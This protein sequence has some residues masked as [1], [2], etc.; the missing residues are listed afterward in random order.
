MTDTDNLSRRRFLQGTGAAATAAA[1]AGCTGGDGDGDDEETET[2]E[3]D[4]GTT[5]TGGDETSEETTEQDYDPSKEVRL[6]GSTMDTLDPVKATDTSSGA[7]IQNIFDGLTNYPEGQTNVENLLAE[8]LDVS[9]D[10]TTLTFSLKQGVTYNN[11]DELTAGDIV[12]S[13]ERLAASENSRRSS[14]LLADLGVA[15]ETETETNEE[16]EE[17]ERYVP[18]SIEVTAVDDYTVEIQLQQAF[19]AATAMIAYS[20]F[21]PIPEGIVGDIEGYDGQMDY[22]EFATTNPVGTGPYE[23]DSWEQATS[24]KLTSRDDYHGEEPTNA[25]LNYTIFQE[26][27]PAYTYATVNVN[28][29]FPVVPNAKFQPDLRSFDGTDDRGRRY[30]TYGPFEENGLT[31]DYYEVSTLDCRYVAFN[32]KQVPKP[33]REAVGYAMN[34]QIITEELITGPAKQAYFFTP[35]GIFPGGPD[36]YTERQQDYKYGYQSS[37]LQAAKQVMEDAGYSADNTYSLSF[38]M[39]NGYASYV[40]EDLFSLLR[41]QLT[42]AHIEMELN[43]AD[44]STFLNRARSGNVGMFMLGWLADYP[45]LDNFLK[46][47]NPPATITDKDDNVGYVNWTED[48]GDFAAQA[49]EG[50][51]QIVDNYGLSESDVEARAEGGWKIEEAAMK[52]AVMLPFMHSIEKGM[53]YPWVSKPRSGAMGGSRQKNHTIKVGDRGEHE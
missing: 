50:W 19:Y 52:D 37:D 28:A 43:T 40:G 15:H 11:G 23:L 31:A 1:L 49:E 47:L 14:F 22:Q 36:A 51:Q 41:D 39:S 9:D 10:Q 29:D 25:A 44:W 3:E 26:T 4:T 27:N 45:G 48:N 46:L 16:G 21:V 2:T 33:V 20:S 53:S 30:G 42:T 7:K 35:P 5:E 32:C 8:S 18:G 24:V 12:Y 38:D 6:T 34:Q 13:W 17:V